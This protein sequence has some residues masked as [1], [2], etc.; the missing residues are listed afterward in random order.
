MFNVIDQRTGWKIDL[1]VCKSRPFSREE[2]QRR[3]VV[4]LQGI[5]VF[6]ASAEDVVISKLEWAHLAQSTRHIEDVSGILRARWDLLD[7]PYLEKWIEELALAGEW[8][9]A[10][11]AAG[12]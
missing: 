10:R 6:V 7:R 5:S 4:Q 12:F 3:R 1:I 11:S 9:Q 8:K 2:F